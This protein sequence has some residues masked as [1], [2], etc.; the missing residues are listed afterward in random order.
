VLSWKLIENLAKC[1]SISR[2]QSA[3]TLY[4]YLSSEASNGTYLLWA[5]NILT[6]QKKNVAD[7][8]G[9][10]SVVVAVVTCLLKPSLP[11]ASSV[12]AASPS[13]TSLASSSSNSNSNSS[14]SSLSS[15]SSLS[16]PAV[17]SSPMV[18]ASNRGLLSPMSHTSL[19]HFS[20]AATDREQQLQEDLEQQF[21]PIPELFS[22]SPLPF[23]QFSFLYDH[24]TPTWLAAT[25]V[26]LETALASSPSSPSAAG[27]AS[28]GAASASA[29]PP[30]RARGY[31]V[32]AVCFNLLSL[33]RNLT[34]NSDT[35]RELD[36]NQQLVPLIRLLAFYQ[37]LPQHTT[38]VGLTKEA[39]HKQLIR[40]LA[41]MFNSACLY[42]QQITLLTQ[43]VPTGAHLSLSLSLSL[44]LFT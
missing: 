7:I 10:A 2:E 36:R 21:I 31:N 37:Y 17:A 6:K 8:S 20:R 30:V 29:S 1:S 15:L 5:L 38:N 3:P 27:S 16:T 22:V 9:L 44:S 32:R 19:A 11:S 41:I 42:S 43:L 25:P 18:G 39:V 26:A 23:H 13:A 12:S 33:L 28:A 24:P 34:A 4:E 14:S 40:V 35:L